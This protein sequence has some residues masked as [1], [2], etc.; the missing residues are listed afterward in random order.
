MGGATLLALLILFSQDKIDRSVIEDE[1]SKR[2]DDPIQMKQYRQLLDD[3]E[4]LETLRE[5]A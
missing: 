4:L 5:T 3:R 2:I 1:I